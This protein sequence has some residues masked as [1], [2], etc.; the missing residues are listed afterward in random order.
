MCQIDQRDG[1]VSFAVIRRVL[2]ELFVKKNIVGGPFAPL[3]LRGFN[4]NYRI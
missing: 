4:Y 3:Q 1:T 2:R